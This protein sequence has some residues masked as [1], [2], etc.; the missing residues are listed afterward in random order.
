MFHL[1]KYSVIRKVKNFSIL[2][3]PFVFPLILGTLFY[4]AFGNISESD[5]ETVQAAFV[6]ENQGDSAFPAFLEEV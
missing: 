5:F 1:I 2:F 6:K 4:F 3:W